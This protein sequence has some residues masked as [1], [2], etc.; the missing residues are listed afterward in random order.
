MAE[1]KVKITAQNQTQ[2]GFQAVLAD[3]QKTATQVQNTFAR[4]SEIRTFKPKELSSGPI[5]VDIGDYGLEPLRELQKQIAEV[6]RS[7]REALDPEVAENFSGGIG[8]LIGRFAILIGVAA[9]VGKVIASAFDQLSE[10]VKSATTIQE[11]FNQSI[12]AA[13]TATNLDGAISGFKQLNALADQTGKN[14][15]ERFGA[16][17]GESLANLFSGRPGQFLAR[18]ADAFTIGGVSSG[19][20]D[21][22]SRQREIAREQLLGSLNRQRINAEERAGAGADPAAI[23]RVQREQQRRQERER[24]INALQGES[25]ELIKAAQLEQEA[26]FAA[27]DRAI[28][29]KEAAEAEKQATREKEKQAA[30]ESGTRRGNVIGRQLGPGS[31]EGIAELERERARAARELGPEFGPGTAEAATGGFRVDAANFA[32]QQREEALR[33]AE[34]AARAS[35]ASGSAGASAFQ[36]IGFASNEFFDTRQKRDPAEETRRAAE[37][38]KQILDILK[39]G[40]PLVLP[41]SS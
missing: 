11:Q 6:R 32:L 20:R 22:E 17:V 4:A 12:E 10:A 34:Q 33:L 28:A 26:T 23:E 38:A 2:T 30:L 9:T 8:G 40:E 5:S 3:A 1:V 31:L 25:S 29:V 13:G 24:L 21:Q 7:A 18:A 27:Q 36:R 39:K 16:G 15:K 37:F 19:L 35:F 41:A 14:I